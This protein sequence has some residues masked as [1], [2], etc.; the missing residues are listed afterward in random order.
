MNIIVFHGNGKKPLR[1]SFGRRQLSWLGAGTAATVLLNLVLGFTIGRSFSTQDQA[2]LAEVDRMVQSVAGQRAELGNMRE[3]HDAHLNALALRLGDL[4]AR[5]TRLEALGARLTQLGQMADGEFSFLESP[6]IGGPE[7]APTLAQAGAI[8][9][10]GEIDEFTLRFDARA[11]QLSVLE[12]LI[13]GRELD[14][15]LTPAGKP[16][17]D[18]WHSSN[19]GQTGRPVYRRAGVPPGGRL[20]GATRGRNPGRS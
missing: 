12:S 13:A 10:A 11:R 18:G 9:L 7:Q 19:Y 1:L 8:D 5:S 3:R 16:I 2:A 20:F 15:T 14:E 17:K 6:P 4:Q